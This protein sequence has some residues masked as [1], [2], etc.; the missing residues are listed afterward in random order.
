MIS[1]T[2]PHLDHAAADEVDAFLADWTPLAL[3]V[4][5]GEDWDTTTDFEAACEASFDLG[6]LAWCGEQLD[7]ERLRLR[8]E[9]ADRCED[10]RSEVLVAR[11]CEDLADRYEDLVAA[12]VARLPAARRTKAFSDLLYAHFSNI[13]GL[14]L[15]RGI[16]PASAAERLYTIYRAGGVPV[17]YD[18]TADRFTVLIPETA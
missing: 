12:V 7:D 1:E 16:D 4:Q 8:N 18:E 5:L 11:L 15:V 14:R 3:P 2:S 17:G 6:W 10:L 13:A 9:C